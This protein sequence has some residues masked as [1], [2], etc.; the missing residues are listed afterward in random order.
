LEDTA[1]SLAFV[2]VRATLDIVK[3]ELVLFVRVTV[4]G[5]LVVPSAWF[6]NAKVAADSVTCRTPVPDRATVCGLLTALS[7]RVR[8]AD[9]APK[10]AGVKA[11]LI[12]QD[13]F[14]P[15]VVPQVVADSEKSPEFVPL[16]AVEDIVTT[17]PV[18]LV[19]VT[20]W[21][22]LVLSIP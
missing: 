4:F 14:N 15:S 1:N 2:P 17:A 8:V 18:L 5:A 20:F 13:F 3:A 22:A 16:I 7:V 6:P 11:M 10:A 19:S 21:A 12:V 9:L